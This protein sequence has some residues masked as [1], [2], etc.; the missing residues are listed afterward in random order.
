MTTMRAILVR[1]PRQAL[2]GLALAAAI[3]IAISVWRLQ[4]GTAAPESVPEA[5]AFRDDI[6]VC[7]GGVGR[8]G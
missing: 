2:I 4:S 6:V 7:V 5:K 8:L 1:V 3:T